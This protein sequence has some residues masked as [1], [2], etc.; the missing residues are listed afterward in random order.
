MSSGLMFF[1][2]FILFTSQSSFMKMKNIVNQPFFVYIM[3]DSKYM[4]NKILYDCGIRYV[5]D[6]IDID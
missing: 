2:S 3:V 4:C 6:V 1:I 5:K